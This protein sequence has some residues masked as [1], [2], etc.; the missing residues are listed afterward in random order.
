ML[1][2]EENT[3]FHDGKVL[4]FIIDSAYFFLLNINM[5][6]VKFIQIF[7]LT[8]FLKFLSF[9][10]TLSHNSNHRKQAQRNK[11]SAGVKKIAGVI[12]NCSLENQTQLKIQF[13]AVKIIF[14]VVPS[15]EKVHE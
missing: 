1:R 2:K 13:R 12:F 3:D 10:L 6:A 15:A 14:S 8:S 4:S 7:V 5:H 11:L 9:Y